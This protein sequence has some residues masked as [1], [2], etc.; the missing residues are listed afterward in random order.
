MADVCMNYRLL[1]II[2]FCQHDVSRSQETAR[3]CCEG[4]LVAEKAE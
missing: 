3:S 4:A 1:I 2:R